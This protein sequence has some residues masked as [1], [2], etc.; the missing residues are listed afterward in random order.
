MKLRL[1]KNWVTRKYFL[2]K[3]QNFR[4]VSIFDEQY[5]KYHSGHPFEV[6]HAYGIDSAVMERDIHTHTHTQTC[7]Y[8]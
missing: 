8:G 1:R 6:N 5:F 2:K 7:S 4:N 3:S